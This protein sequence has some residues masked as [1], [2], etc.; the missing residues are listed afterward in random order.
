MCSKINKTPTSEVRKR[1]GE[2]QKEKNEMSQGEPSQH[3][4]PQLKTIS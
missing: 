1:D 4:K 3:T 2:E